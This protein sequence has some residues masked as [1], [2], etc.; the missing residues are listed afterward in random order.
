MMGIGCSGQ[1]LAFGRK[2]IFNRPV[3]HKNLN[4]T[5]LK[6]QILLKIFRSQ[7]SLT[8]AEPR[9]WVWV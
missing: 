2:Y 3:K 7:K 9:C 1:M 4:G 5:F 8:I 6:A